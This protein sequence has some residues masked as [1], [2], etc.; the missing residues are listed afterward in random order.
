MG[1][2]CSLPSSRASDASAA[3]RPTWK[4]LSLPPWGLA[5]FQWDMSSGVGFVSPLWMWLGAL[6]RTSQ[7]Q[8]G[9]RLPPQPQFLHSESKQ[10]TDMGESGFRAL[11][12]EGCGVGAPG[13]SPR[14]S[15]GGPSVSSLGRHLAKPCLARSMAVPPVSGGDDS[16]QDDVCIVSRLA[17]TRFSL[18]RSCGAAPLGWQVP[19]T[20]RVTPSLSVLVLCVGVFPAPRSSACR[21]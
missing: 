7:G 3:S 19:G 20:F 5:Q 14:I 16:Q 4:G 12:G 10:G 18:T 15:P 8:W 17:H 21:R 11:C 2:G 13:A 1:W 6:S 9:C